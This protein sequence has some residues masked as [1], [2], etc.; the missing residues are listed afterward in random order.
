MKRI[1]IIAGIIVA[2]VLVAWAIISF[3]NAKRSAPRYLTA[4]VTRANIDAVIQETGTVNPVNEVQVGTQVSGTISSLNVDYNSIVHKGQVLATLDPTSFEA[5]EAQAQAAVMSAQANESAAQATVTQMG[6]SVQSAQANYK[7][8]LAAQTLAQTTMTRDKQLV[9][10]GYIAQSQY[11]TDAAA[12]RSAIADASAAHDAVSA[13]QAQQNASAHQAGASGAQVASAQGQLQQASYNL[14]R[15]TITSPIDG[16]VVSRAVSIGQTV[17]ASFQTPTLFVIA[18]SLKDMQVDVSV[19][20]ADVGQLAVGQAASITVPA[21]PNTT[22][23]GTVTQIRVNPTNVQNVVTYDTIVMIHD[24]SSRLKPGMTANVTIAVSRRNNVLA[25]PVAALLY[26]PQGAR[27][28]QTQSAPGS[29]GSFTA[30]VATP[31]PT[32]GAPGSRVVVWALSQKRPKPV[33]VVIGMSDGS[34]FEIRSGDLK[35]GDRVIIG[36]LQSRSGGSTT[37]FAAGPGGR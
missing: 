23:K 4:P 34:N 22:F 10:Q 27:Q 24:E 25:V 5:A 18:S 36:Q 7:K 19:D 30:G 11:D 15:A 37:P 12:L 28:S 13:A 32:A 3:A 16:I 9:A 1:Y 31:P 35:E 20:E 6:A 2:V 21:Y 14:Q 26:K 29:S 33:Q 8:A 17:A